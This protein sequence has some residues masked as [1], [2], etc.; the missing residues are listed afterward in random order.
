MWGGGDLRPDAR[1]SKVETE[2]NSTG[3]QLTPLELDTLPARLR[4]CEMNVARAVRLQRLE[5][6]S[7]VTIVFAVGERKSAVRAGFG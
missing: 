5:E 7:G 1:I 6:E 3:V 2:L 4:G